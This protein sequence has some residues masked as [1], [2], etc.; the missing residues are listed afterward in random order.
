M[1]VIVG[2]VMG[3]TKRVTQQSVVRN[4]V[5]RVSNVRLTMCFQVL[6]LFIHVIQGET[7]SF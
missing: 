3:Q 7:A 6:S 5:N 4:A 1:N 2:G